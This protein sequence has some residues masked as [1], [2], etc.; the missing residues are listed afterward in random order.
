VWARH[1]VPVVTFFVRKVFRNVPFDD[2]PERN[3]MK[4]VYITHSSIGK[5]LE[6]GI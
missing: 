6:I 4:E 3:A 2:A 1:R 5:I